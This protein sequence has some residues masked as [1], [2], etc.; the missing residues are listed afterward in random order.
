MEQIATDRT[1]SRGARGRGGHV[2]AAAGATFLAALC[3]GFVHAAAAA[4]G[5]VDVLIT[6]D[7]RSAGVEYVGWRSAAGSGWRDPG[8]G[9]AIRF[10]LAPGK[11][12]LIVWL[13][14]SKR[15]QHKDDTLSV[16]FNGHDLGTFQRGKAEGWSRWR[17]T[18]RPEAFAAGKLQEL[19]FVRRGKPIAVRHVRICNFLPKEPPAPAGGLNRT[20]WNVHARRFLYAPTF[21]VAPVAGAGSY[22]LTVQ[23]RTGK[24]RKQ[25]KS[26]SAEIDLAG[27]WDALPCAGRYT[28]WI[29]ALDAGGKLLGRTKSFDFHKVA[30]F[31]G[32]TTQPKCDYVESGRRCAEYVMA[33]WLAGWKTAE[34][35][36][37]PP[38]KYPC[39]FYSAYVRLLV[40]Y[41]RLDPQS[42]QGRRAMSLAR[43]IGLHMARTGTPAD[44][45]YPN[46][47]LSHGG[48]KVLQI[49]RTA[50]AGM[51][52]LDLLAA[53]REKAFLQAAMKIADTLKATQL[54]DG[55][56]HFRVDPRSGK[57]AEDYTSDQAE[58]IFFLDDLIARHGRPDLAAARDKAV[59]WM[60]ANPVKTR[61]WQQQWDDVPL[62]RP[63]VNLEFYD[64]VFFGLYLLRHATAKNGY[65]RIAA[66][67]FRYVED[68][69]VLWES[70]YNP[71]FIAPGVKEQ[72]L[73]YIPIDWHAAHF[74]RFCMAMHRATGQEVY[75]EKARSMAD[76]LTA[77]QH[78][79]G[80]Y[81][82]W[83]RRKGSGIDYGG[84]WP[85]CS[86]YTGEMMIKLGTYVRGLKRGPA[87]QPSAMRAGAASAIRAAARAPWPPGG[88][89]PAIRAACCS[90]FR[91]GPTWAT[92]ASS[93]FPRSGPSACPLRPGP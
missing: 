7:P 59:A 30:P 58:A 55:R 15:P 81:P 44:W 54:P 39:L 64:T 66:E 47:P 4:P 6:L 24:L 34:P 43:K 22:R 75:L 85:N 33:K 88:A 53:S 80:F 82:T 65:T 32:R 40:T 18:I 17:A 38:V 71:A 46:V 90:P 50:M 61:H 60:L 68:Q 92:A 52:Y 79:D 2:A 13:Y 10:A 63:Y 31:P 72:Y 26:S 3:P 35:G 62:R 86:S 89:A 70:S 9:S 29:E 49:S 48:G 78:P 91:P 57:V 51:A 5:V 73:C 84:I 87:A 28:A 41:A 93:S 83:M 21:S 42:P 27:I 11:Y 1:A 19:R 69:F 37:G 67:L 77:V 45:A 76:T 23:A 36:K 25:A 14:D 74:I 16:R 56:W 12:F 20:G 8:E